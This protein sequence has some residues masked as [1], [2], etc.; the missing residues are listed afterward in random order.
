MN[1]R[2]EAKPFGDW[3]KKVG[4]IPEMR[5]QMGE[6][7]LAALKYLL[8]ELEICCWG[9]KGIIG[10]TGY[11][12]CEGQVKFNLRENVLTDLSQHKMGC[13]ER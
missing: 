11:K 1:R 12:W 7:L 4:F 2:L 10:S 9:L 3:L 13:L 8:E 5:F 6:L